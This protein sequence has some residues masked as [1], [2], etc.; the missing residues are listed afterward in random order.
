MSVYNGN[1]WF[2]SIRVKALDIQKLVKC[3]VDCLEI[4]F[5]P[6]LVY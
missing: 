1:D 5:V 3:L 2:L 6:L 4:L